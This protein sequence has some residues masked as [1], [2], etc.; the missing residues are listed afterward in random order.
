MDLWEYTK[1]D[2]GT[3]GLND[4]KSLTDAGTKTTGYI[5]GRL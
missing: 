1:L 5:L 2:D 4:S 3:Y